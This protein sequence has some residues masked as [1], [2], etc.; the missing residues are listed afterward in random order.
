MGVTLGPRVL[1]DVE[2]FGDG[3]T[4]TLVL[5][6]LVADPVDAAR[7]L[8]VHAVAEPVGVDEEGVSKSGSRKFRFRVGTT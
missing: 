8:L 5:L 2:P 3:R 6:L 4:S 7:L 1:D